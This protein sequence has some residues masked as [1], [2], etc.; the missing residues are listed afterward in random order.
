MGISKKDQ[1]YL[2]SALEKYYGTRPVIYLK[3]CSE[4]KYAEDVCEGKLYANTPVWFRNKEIESGERGQGDKHELMSVIEFQ[5]AI[6]SDQETGNIL[7]DGLQGTFEIRYESDDK[8]P[9]VCFVGL[10]L[11]DLKMI[12]VNEN[13]MEFVFPFSDDEYNTM[14]KKFGKYCVVIDGNEFDKKIS[15]YSKK[16]DFYTI[17]DSVKYCANNNLDRMEAFNK[18]I[19]ER[20]LYKDNDLSYQ[21]EFRL[22]VD[23]EIPDDHYI[24]IGKVSNATILNSEKLK[25]M[26][27]TFYYTSHRI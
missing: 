10:T 17:F 19:K 18:G 21:R 22:V 13:R 15:N 5:E 14:E 11:R 1:E 9:M 3:F 20:F 7:M 16:Y 8:I 25:I 26:K 12:C 24:K 27:F 4:M 23:C 6:V 2:I